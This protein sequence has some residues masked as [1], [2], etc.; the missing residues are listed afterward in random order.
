MIFIGISRGSG[1]PKTAKTNFWLPF[2]GI[3]GLTLFQIA[4]VKT[5]KYLTSRRKKEVCKF[6]SSLPITLSSGGRLALQN[7]NFHHNAAFEFQL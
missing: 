3:S 4:T 6:A 5:I 7:S 1:M 2:L